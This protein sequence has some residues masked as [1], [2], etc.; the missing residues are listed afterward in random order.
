MDVILIVHNMRKAFV[1]YIVL[2]KNKKTYP[3]TDTLRFIIM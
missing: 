1:F 2:S 3:K